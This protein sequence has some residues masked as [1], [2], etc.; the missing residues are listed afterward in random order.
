M[1]TSRMEEYHTTHDQMTN[2]NNSDSEKKKNK[3]NQNKSQWEPTTS[4]KQNHSP[5]KQLGYDIIVILPILYT[6][7]KVRNSKMY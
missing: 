3:N 6:C 2:D 4:P 5:P 1:A 7:H